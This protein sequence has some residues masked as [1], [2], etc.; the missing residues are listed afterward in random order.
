MDSWIHAVGRSAGSRVADVSPQDG[1]R[2]VDAN[3]VGVHLATHYTLRLLARDS[4]LLF[5]CAVG[6]QPH[7]PRLSAYASAKAGHEACVRFL[8]EEKH[9]RRVTMVRPAAG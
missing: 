6:G 7:L 9:K 4:H 8:D 5:L 3:L 1:Q 2:I